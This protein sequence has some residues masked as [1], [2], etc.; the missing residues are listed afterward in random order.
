MHD[1][2]EVNLWLALAFENASSLRESVGI[3]GSTGRKQLF[4]VL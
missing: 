1:L 2:A 3:S 4:Y